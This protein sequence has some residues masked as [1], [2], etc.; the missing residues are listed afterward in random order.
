MARKSPTWDLGGWISR[1]CYDVGSLLRRARRW[2]ASGVDGTDGQPDWGEGGGGWLGSKRS[3]QCVFKLLILTRMYRSS[4]RD[5]KWCRRVLV[6]VVSLP[7]RQPSGVLLLNL[8][9]C[10]IFCVNSFCVCVWRGFCY[11]PARQR[12]AQTDG[13]ACNWFCVLRT[14]RVNRLYL[15]T[16]EILNT[17]ESH[18]QLATAVQ[19]KSAGGQKS[20]RLTFVE[21]I[22]LCWRHK[23][24]STRVPSFFSFDYI[25][26]KLYK[27]STVTFYNI[28]HTPF[29]TS[30]CWIG[31]TLLLYD[32]CK[33]CQENFVTIYVNSCATYFKLKMSFNSSDVANAL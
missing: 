24:V 6:V 22:N 10:F 23:V 30:V 1:S 13:L 19:G 26:T 29:Y 27:Q 28:R 33:A 12:P 14:T 18:P 3:R 25:V 32:Y 2:E 7:A 9:M 17:M 4:H 8:M 5:G 31:F 16:I 20:V 15:T 21:W 11:S